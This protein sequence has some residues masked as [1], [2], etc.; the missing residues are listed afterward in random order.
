MWHAIVEA[1]G[2]CIGVTLWMFM[3]ATLTAVVWSVI[4]IIGNYAIHK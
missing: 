3:M 2:W 1:F 4:L